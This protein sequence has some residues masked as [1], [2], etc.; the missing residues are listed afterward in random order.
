MET[1]Q[2]IHERM[3]S[4]IDDEYDKSDGSFIY[5]A[6]KPSA[7]EFENVQK[8]IAKVQ[9]K[10]DVEK[11]KDVE[12]ERFVYQ[13]TGIERKQ[14]TKATTTVI[15]SGSAGSVIR[16][17]D[18]VGTDT[19]NFLSLEEKV[20]GESGFVEV[21][22]ECE[23]YGSI[24]N[25]PANSITT[26]PVTISGLVDVYNPE[27][28]TNGYD[29]ES[30]NDLRKRYYDKLQRPGKAGNKYHYLEW[31]KE[32]V[33]VGDARVFPRFNGPLTMKVVIIDANKQ[34]A[35]DE[36]VARVYNHISEEMPFGVEDLNVSSATGVPININVDLTIADGFTEEMAINSIKENVTKYL[37][38]LAFK[39]SFV[40][41]AK[42]GSLIIDSEGVLDYQNLLVNG[43]TANIPIAEDEVAIVGGVNE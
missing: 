30:D 10:T 9:E 28:V 24:G 27:K 43:G 23:Q 15:I 13:R 36:L 21:L 32:V 34:P 12:L 2:E 22:V 19:I 16:V 3:L 38:E 11:L 17:G 40:S 29:A 41:Y 35:S 4:N 14:A 7:I 20:I 42:I 37:Q 1:V 39:Q 18:L 26:F 31:A 5:D 6:T 8:R 33:G 25:V